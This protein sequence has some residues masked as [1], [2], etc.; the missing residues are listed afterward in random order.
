M[1]T[2]TKVISSACISTSGSEARRERGFT[3]FMLTPAKGVCQ[4]TEKQDVL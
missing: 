3:S 4:C 1:L 2:A